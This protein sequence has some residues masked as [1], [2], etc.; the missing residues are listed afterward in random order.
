M[1][2]ALFTIPLTCLL[3]YLKAQLI[4]NTS[5][6]PTQLAQILAGPG[7]SVSGATLLC[8]PNGY[9]SF[10]NGNTTNLGINSG[11]VLTTG[12]ATAIPQPGTAFASTD[13]ATGGDP[14]LNLISAAST[15][16]VC[17]LTFNIV[18]VGNTLTFQYVFGSEEYP[19]YVCSQFND[20]FGFFITGP[21][22]GGGA[23]SSA[24]IAFIPG[25]NTTVSI[26]TVNP[27]VPG[28][29][30]SSSGCQSLSYSNYYIDNQ[31][32]N[33]IVYDG[34]TTV[35]S[36]SIA[37]V[38]CAT[39]TMKLAIGDAGDGIYDSGVFIQSNSFTSVGTTV[40]AS[41]DPG[42]T[43]AFEGCSKGYFTVTLPQP[44]TSS[45]VIN[46]TLT[47]TAA[48][49][50]D[51]TSLSGVAHVNPGNTTTTITVNPIADGITE[52][53]ETV[54]IN[55]IN[56]CDGTI[57]TSATL[58][59]ND[60]PNTTATATP[61]TICAGQ[62]VQLQAT[63]GGTYAWSASSGTVSNP[64]IANPTAQPSTTTT[65]TV[66]TT[67]GTC[68]N[69]ASTTVNVTNLNLTATASPNTPVCPGTT[70]NLS[71]QLT[72]G[73]GNV[74]YT[75]SGGTVSNPNAQNTTAN[76]TTTTTYTVTASTTNG[77]TATSS[78]TV[79]VNPSPQPNLGPNQSYCPNVATSATLSPSG[80]PY[81]SYSWSTS[82]TAP[83]I[84]V[85][86]TGTYSVTVTDANGCS[87]SAS[88][89]VTFHPITSA[90]LND[91]VLCS[92]QS[93]TLNALPGLTNIQ[94]N[95]NSNA[96]SITVNTVGDYYYTAT[97]ANGCLVRSDTANITAGNSPIVNLTASP[98]TICPNATSVL[99]PNASGTGLTYLW[100]PGNQNT[101]TITVSTPGTYIVEVTNAQNCKTRDTV[102]VY[103]H[104]AP[105]PNLGPNQTHCSSIT[106]SVTL[107]PSGG[108]YSAYSWSNQSTT[109]SIIVNSSGTYSVTVTGINGCTGSASVAITFHP[110]TPA[111]LSD[112]SICDGQSITLSAV[113]GLTN[114]TWSNNATTN[115]ITV[116]TP[117]N[118]YYTATDANGCLV[119]SDTANVSAGPAP[120]VN[121]TA[122]PDTICANGSSILTANASG[123]GLT[124]LWIP[125]GQNTP[126]I[127]V[128]AP[129]TYIVEVTNAQLCKKRDTVTVYQYTIPPVLLN[130][131]TTVCPGRPVT[132][133]VSGGPY[134]SY[135]WSNSNT[136]P[137]ITV[138]TPG[139]YQVTVF[140]GQCIY[141][142]DVF[143]LSNFTLV[144]P[145]AFKDTTVCAG[146]P[147]TLTSQPGFSNYVWNNSLAGSQI[148]VTNAGA[149]SYTATDANGCS[150]TSTTATVTH[151]PLPLPDII[152]TP[153]VICIGQ[154][155]TTLNAGSETGVTYTWTPG[156]ATGNTIQVTNPGTYYV[157]ASRNGC[158]AYDS[159]V[160]FSSDTPLLNLP[161]L[162]KSCCQSVTLDPAPGL[163]YT[164][165]WSD[166]SNG[167]T[168]SITSTNNNTLSYSV[169]ATNAVGCTASNT[170]AV[171]IKCLQLTALAEP[172]T[173]QFGESSQL[174]A[175]TAYSGNLSY[176]WTPSSTLSNDTIADPIA[177]PENTTTYHV[178][179]TDRDDLC[180]D[181]ASV[182]IFVVS[183][184][185]AIPNAFTPNGDGRNDVFY[186]VN[187]FGDKSIITFRIY[188]RWGALIHD[189]TTGWDGRYEGKDQ[190]AGTYLYYLVVRGLNPSTGQFE[191]KNYNGSFSLIR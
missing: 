154:G 10:T 137:T 149:Y 65:Y 28:S 126:T 71:A 171:Q 52:G 148:T 25:T 90:P 135:N 46:Y 115:T 161:P 104:I 37:V 105:Q 155:S 64:N 186:P 5:Q 76:P 75:W 116:T 133:S 151:I 8:G 22:P 134:V 136:T 188:N 63:G 18:P 86:T 69:T 123:S 140:D 54:T 143:T 47:G 182:T 49:G 131:D 166:N 72:G 106:S 142:S 51:Y 117:G 17:I 128:N 30:Y 42:F 62:T 80:G 162:V 100:I 130:N 177:K 91:A 50:T 60:A 38:P 55:I 190:P 57:L 2:K 167:P 83:S 176:V 141:T 114:I 178:K 94:W 88:V 108:P 160:I 113:S 120:T 118:Y 159:I 165:Q 66:T 179:V 89:S 170:T 96:S 21:N 92:G 164:F 79:N 58:N 48:N 110:K 53:Q 77:C 43:S 78:V 132:V 111:P 112:N 84:I 67:F 11:I 27:G 109:P 169:T 81:S 102:V 6:T 191:D 183:P 139:N 122:S 180:I 85:N 1:K 95:T 125:G 44:A 163:N 119:K 187:I 93:I 174:S 124:Y 35:F 68:V 61:S 16:D 20:V 153:P 56:P 175:N 184:G 7:V 138:T 127:T 103:S 173:I 146:Q 26:N 36:A 98:D 181:S 185:I 144:T 31:F 87:G 39:Y 19:E 13:N 147:V 150:V 33:T 24:N 121:L 29:G 74:N 156:G 73:S 45:H 15:Q 40:T 12:T 172:D 4:V 168:L 101:P 152:A 82:S 59:I 34:F 41:Y 23:Y 9:G 129:G 97:D 107:S 32:G 158:L 3:V 14:D 157:T 189:N 70:V 145:Q 99:N